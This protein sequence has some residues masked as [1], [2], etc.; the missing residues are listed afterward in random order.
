MANHANRHF[1]NITDLLEV[2]LTDELYDDVLLWLNLKHLQY[3]AE[4]WSWFHIST[5]YTTDIFQLH[6]FI[7][8]Q[9]SYKP[10]ASFIYYLK[11]GTSHSRQYLRVADI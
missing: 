2:W 10:N 1:Q 3:E 6:G 7:H 9:F 11:I 5:I 4:E 8:K